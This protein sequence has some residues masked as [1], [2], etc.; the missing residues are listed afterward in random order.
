MSDQT[1]HIQQVGN[2]CLL[3]STAMA[4]GL[5][6]EEYLDLVRLGGKYQFGGLS[7]IDAFPILNLFGFCAGPIA[8]F[9][10]EID[11]ENN[12]SRKTKPVLLDRH[13]VTAI[14]VLAGREE[15]TCDQ[16]IGDILLRHIESH[17]FKL[18]APDFGKDNGLEVEG[19]E[20][21]KIKGFRLDVSI[22]QPA[23]VA[24]NTDSDSSSGHAVYWS[25]K[26]LY[27]PDCSEI[28][29]NFDGYSIR[30]WVPIIR[31]EDPIDAWFDL[32]ERR[33]RNA[34]LKQ[35]AAERAASEGVVETPDMP[36]ELIRNCIVKDSLGQIHSGAIGEVFTV[37][38]CDAEMLIKI[39]RAKKV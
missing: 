9:A 4:C 3:A 7:I 5:S 14:E 20:S 35:R 13:V 1:T 28:K 18:E 30:Q 6:Q 22:A 12:E 34:I 8:S 2:T 29:D 23:I 32:M 16:Y 17:G 27:D 37:G 26:R 21:A 11:F 36:V 15:T 10:V 24:V 33:K 38:G 19:L 31:A 25:G 39:G